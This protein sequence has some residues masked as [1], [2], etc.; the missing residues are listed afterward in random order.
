MHFAI[1]IAVS[2]LLCVTL[3]FLVKL[4][5]N[6][7]VFYQLNRELNKHISE[8]FRDVRLV[9]EGR[10]EEI[11][12]SDESYERFVCLMDRYTKQKAVLFG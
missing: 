8:V 10:G 9:Q 1:L 5:Y 11:D 12:P 4:C 6:V 2:I 3:L 7:W